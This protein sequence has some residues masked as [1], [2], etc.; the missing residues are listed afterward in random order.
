MRAPNLVVWGPSKKRDLGHRHVQRKTMRRHGEEKMDVCKPRW[1]TSD[2][3][4]PADTLISDFWP[5]GL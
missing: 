3:T 1:E 4:N 5:P 2:E